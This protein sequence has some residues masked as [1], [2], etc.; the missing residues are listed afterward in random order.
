MDE[1]VYVLCWDPAP[2]GE[3]GEG[4]PV[5]GPVVPVLVQPVPAV[6]EEIGAEPGRGI[7]EGVPLLANPVEGGVK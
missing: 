4:V 5:P 7:P 3:D 2:A 1:G 6:A